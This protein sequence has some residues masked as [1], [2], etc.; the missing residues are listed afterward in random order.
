MATR[1]MGDRPSL[2]DRSP[3]FRRSVELARHTMLPQK[4]SSRWTRMGVA[5]GGLVGLGVLAYVVTGSLG[6]ALL[7]LLVGIPVVVLP[8]I[9]LV[10]IVLEAREQ[11]A[12][13]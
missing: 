4:R 11:A 10:G 6:W 1:T 8:V 9:L 13:R 2:Y 3:G 12:S 7:S 5:V